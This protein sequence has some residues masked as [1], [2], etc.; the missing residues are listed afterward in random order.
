MRTPFVACSCRLRRHEKKEKSI[1]T[2]TPRTPAKG[3]ALCTPF[4]VYQR[5]TAQLSWFFFEFYWKFIGSFSSLSNL[6]SMVVLYP[7]ASDAITQHQTHILRRTL[8]IW[9]TH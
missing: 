5:I 3:C 6:S 7:M 1:F 9:L 4:I 8:A 2:G